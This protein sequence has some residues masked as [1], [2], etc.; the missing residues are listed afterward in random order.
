MEAISKNLIKIGNLTCTLQSCGRSA[1][2]EHRVN[3]MFSILS[4]ISH[5]PG[6]AC[7][8]HTS[9]SSEMKDLPTTDLP[10]EQIGDVPLVY[11]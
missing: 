2:W 10:Y 1:K 7:K 9:Q 3:E 8:R 6:L 11:G 5:L 4:G